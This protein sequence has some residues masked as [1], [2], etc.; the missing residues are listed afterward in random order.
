MFTSTLDF[1]SS[2]LLSGYDLLDKIESMYLV[3]KLVDAFV[4]SVDILLRLSTLDIFTKLEESFNAFLVIS[5]IS[6]YKASS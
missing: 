6:D 5:T 2:S 3:E 4:L 1:K